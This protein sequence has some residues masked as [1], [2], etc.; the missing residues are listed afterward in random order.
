MTTPAGMTP[1]P[2]LEPYIYDPARQAVE[3]IGWLN[4]VKAPGYRLVTFGVADLDETVTMFPGSL[5]AIAGRPG[6]GK[7]LVCKALAAR[8]LARIR[9]EDAPELVVFVTLEESPD[10][11][12]AAING[13]G[14]SSRDIHRGRFDLADYTARVHESVVRPGLMMLAHPGIV[15]TGDNRR[16]ADPLTSRRILDGIARIEAT[17]KGALRPRLVVLDYLQLLQPDRDRLH[18]ERTKVAEVMAAVEGAKTIARATGAAVV[19][20]VQAGRE[21]DN[22]RPPMP[23]L[24]DMQ[25]ASAIEQACDTVLGVLRPIRHAAYE[26]DPAT[27]ERPDFAF[28]GRNYPVT[29]DLTVLSV[30][31]QRHGEGHGTF[32]ASLDPATLTMGDHQWNRI[33]AR[34]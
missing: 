31:K 11:V 32:I 14:L 9:E 27:G 29:E 23:N 13:L 34:P 6:M 10:M 4:R 16:L 24:G 30:V 28:K 15:G 18:N 21:S 20:A 1:L 17:T 26:Y 5:T 25:W 22:R 3:I 19:M 12:S 33:G 7:S 2:E 8:E